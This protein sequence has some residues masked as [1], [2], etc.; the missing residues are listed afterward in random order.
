MGNFH[1]LIKRIQ[2][3]QFSTCLSLNHL[4]DAMIYA[5]DVCL[6]LGSP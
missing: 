5:Y 4:E 3:K 1:L 6:Y 2:Q